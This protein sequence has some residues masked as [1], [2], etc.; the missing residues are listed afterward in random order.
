VSLKWAWLMSWLSRLPTR[1]VGR[2]WSVKLTREDYRLAKIA[3]EAYVKQAGGISLATGDK[4]P[5]FELLGG[6]IQDAWAAAAIAVRFDLTI[7]TIRTPARN[8]EDLEST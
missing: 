3:Y 5:A 1:N 6:E 7:E 4:L 8:S 2:G